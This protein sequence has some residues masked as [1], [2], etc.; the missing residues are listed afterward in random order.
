MKILGIDPGLVNTGW[1]IL[2]KNG[3]NDIEYIDCGVFRTKTTDGFGQKLSYIYNSAI[4]I[5][6]AHY[7]DEVAMEEVFVNMNPESSK[8]LIMA[9]TASYVAVCNSERFVYEYRPNTIKKN[10]T[11]NGHASKLQVFVMIKK[12]IKG[13]PKENIQLS[14]DST[15]AMAVALCHAFAR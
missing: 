6:S 12:I 13:L 1:C 3:N 2:N 5:I 7:P 8:K 15:D 9:R 11:G 10:V 4:E 14:H